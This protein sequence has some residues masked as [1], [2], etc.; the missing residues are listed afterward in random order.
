MGANAPRGPPGTGAG[1][2]PGRS[3]AVGG[4]GGA[5]PRGGDGERVFEIS[6]GILRPGA[7]LNEKSALSGAEKANFPVCS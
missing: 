6:C 2:E 4:I 1:F 5:E 7:G 3:W